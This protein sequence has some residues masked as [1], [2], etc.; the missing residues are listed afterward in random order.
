MS[1]MCHSKVDHCQVSEGWFWSSGGEVCVRGELAA[2]TGQNAEVTLSS[3]VADDPRVTVEHT[4]TGMT[5]ISGSGDPA[6]DGPS[7]PVSTVST[8]AE[9]VAD[10]EPV[11]EA[12][13]VAGSEPGPTPRPG[14]AADRTREPCNASA[15]TLVKKKLTAIMCAGL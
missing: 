14:L 15:R 10:A 13:P 8:G 3:A 11:A 12:E 9:P 1:P 6:D 2:E 5:V 7:P 4:T